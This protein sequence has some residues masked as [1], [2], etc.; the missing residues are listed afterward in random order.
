MASQ[1]PAGLRTAE[2]QR[3][4]NRANQLAKYKPIVTYWCEYNILQYVLNNDL[5]TT[6]PECQQFALSLMDKLE[7]YKAENASNDAIVDDVAAKAYIEN[8]AL[9]TFARAD[10]AQRANKVSKQ[11]ADTFMAAATFLDLLGIWGELDAEVKAKSKFAKFHAARILR[12]SKA[13]ED[14]NDTNPVVE[15]PPQMPA[16]DGLEAELKAIEDQQRN[17]G[18][19]YRPPTVESTE[20]SGV[21]SQSESTAAR[22]PFAQP[23]LPQQTPQASAP[24]EHEVSPIDPPESQPIDLAAARQNSVGGGYFPT[25]AQQTP[26]I[27]MPDHDHAGPAQTPSSMNPQ[28][29]YNTNAQPPIAPSPGAFGLGS[30]NRPHRPPPETASLQPSPAVQLPPPQTVPSRTVPAPIQSALP[31]GGYRTDDQATMEA[32]K[33]ARWAISALN[34]EDVNTAVRELRIALQALGAS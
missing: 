18:P 3:F 15:E 5:H 16:E 9:E 10:E 28:D 2:V 7:Q 8:F 31:A 32:Q 21:P 30:P 34:F 13:G 24:T 4:A 27:E 17:G 11:T 25:L 12:A 14:P 26:D 29:F 19:V 23:P 6:D 1:L 33:H 22:S 20:H